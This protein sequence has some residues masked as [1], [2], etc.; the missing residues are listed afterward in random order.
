METDRR[1]G[2]MTLAVRMGRRNAVAL[3]RMLVL[4]AFLVLPI[5]LVAGSA[6][7]LPMIGVLALP[8]AVGPMRTMS[9]RTD[10]PSLNGAL[11]ATGA[12]LGVFSLLVSVG[13]LL[14]S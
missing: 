1:A 12:L 14:A 13:L 2:K 11:A 10:G 4:G 7:A 3:Y 6:S 8:M 9:N 5:S